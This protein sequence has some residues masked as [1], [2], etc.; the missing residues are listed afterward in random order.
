MGD[1]AASVLARLKNKA[2]ENGR[3]YQLCLQPF[4]AVIES[5]N[6][7]KQWTTLNCEWI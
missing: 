4:A 1:M 7:K 5:E 3:S 6:F 2:K